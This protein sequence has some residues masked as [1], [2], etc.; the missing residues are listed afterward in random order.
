MYI[1]CIPKSS[2]FFKTPYFNFEVNTIIWGISEKKKE[3]QGCR[4]LFEY[5]VAGSNMIP[6][7]PP[8]EKQIFPEQKHKFRCNLTTRYLYLYIK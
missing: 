4:Q 7:P 6:P 8:T 3:L 1:Y 5:G 2:G